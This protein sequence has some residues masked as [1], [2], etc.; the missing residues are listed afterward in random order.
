MRMVCVPDDANC[1]TLFCCSQYALSCHPHPA[2]P[3]EAQFSRLI[4]RAL[5]EPIAYSGLALA[6]TASENCTHT[7]S[8]YFESFAARSRRRTWNA[9]DDGAENVASTKCDG[10][11]SGV[12]GVAH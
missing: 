3:H 10:A 1:T 7:E 12:S 4:D 2:T 6:V 9:V 8:L 11:A 5:A